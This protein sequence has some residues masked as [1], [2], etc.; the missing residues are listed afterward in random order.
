MRKVKGRKEGKERGKEE[1]RK[2]GRR[3]EEKDSLLFHYFGEYLTI[4]HKS[5][6]FFNNMKT[7]LPKFSSELLYKGQ[8]TVG[9]SLFQAK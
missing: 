4:F 7:S 5:F 1:S 2:A 8:L 9:N 6:N 3:K